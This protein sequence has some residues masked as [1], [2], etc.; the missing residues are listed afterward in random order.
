MKNEDQTKLRLVEELNELRQKVKKSEKS[1][2]EHKIITEALLE[3]ENLYRM[4][5][6]SAND[7]IIIHDAKGHIFDVNQTMYK[8]LGYTKQELLKMSLKDLVTPEF[9]KKVNDRVSRLKEEGVAIFESADQ[10]K[11]GTAMPVEVS[12]RYI[13]YKGQ[14][15]ILS[16]VRDIHERKLAEDL[17]MSTYQ[18]KEILLEE[19]KRHT[20]YDL[21]I[22]SRILE[23]GFSA[24]TK[25]QEAESI[26]NAQ[27]RIKI[28]TFIKER[29][30][31]TPSVSKIDLAEPI[32]QMVRYMS[33][34]YPVGIKKIQI[35]T[36]I[37]N[38]SLD[39]ARA[40]TLSLIINEL[41]SNSLKHA[42]P[43]DR[44]G[45]I[46]INL[47][48]AECGTQIL[49]FRDNGIGFPDT[50]D[51]RKASTVGLQLVMDLVDQLNGEIELRRNQGTEFIVQ[52]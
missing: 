47:R 15:V 11:D 6:E 17:I 16:I 7:G 37:Q 23:Q 14:K 32:K 24:F 41:L 30:Y 5:F 50:V 29:M 31:R 1:E 27:N 4:I 26:K 8:R 21:E 51:F 33:S 52:F 12:A 46:I 3:S 38:T 40:I 34:L 2:L 18:E 25:R 45:E 49:R 28:M 13:D 44:K 43:D 19:V 20:K 42:F 9:A 22:F 10:R 36:E 48:K 35:Q 39:L